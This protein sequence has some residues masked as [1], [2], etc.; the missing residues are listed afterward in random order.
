MDFAVDIETMPDLSMI[1]LLPEVKASKTL[2]DPVKIEN[3]LAEKK[4]KQIAEMS[5]DPVF[6][7]VICIGIYNPKQK[8]ILMG[9][10]KDIITKFWDV[11]GKHGQIFTYNGRNFDIDVLLKRGLKYNIG[12]FI[13]NSMLFN[14][15][16][17]GGRVVDIMEVFCKYGE[18]RKLDTLANV[19]L[20]KQKN[21]IDF[22]DFPELMKTSEGR[23]IIGAYCL[24]DAQLTWELAEK[25]GYNLEF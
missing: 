7:K 6:A 9:D 3:D 18:H 23:E 5:L 17:M 21:D 10:E 16:K 15:K 1:D 13:I 2:K 8:Y 22:N 19:Y 25:F 12:N 4:A 11:I 14:P 20:G 24:K